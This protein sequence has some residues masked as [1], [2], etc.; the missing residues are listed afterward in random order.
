MILSTP[1]HKVKKNQI[2]KLKEQLDHIY[3]QVDAD[4]FIK[5]D[6]IQIPKSFNSKQDIE[7][8]AF[9]ASILAWGQRQTIIKNVNAILDGMDNSPYEFIIDHEETDLKRFKGFVHR[10]FNETDLLYFIEALRSLYTKYNSLEDAFHGRGVKERISNFRDQFFD[11]EFVPERTYKHIADPRKGS[12]A[13]RLNMYLRWMVRNDQ[14]D[15]GIWTSIKAN[16]LKCPLDVHVRRSAEYLGLLNR[17]QNDWKAVEELSDNL[18]LL[19]DKDPMK[20]DIS[21]FL[22]SE[23]KL[24]E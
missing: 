4:E 23:M 21:L 22:M 24:I 17:K 18:L 14:L 7:I 15:L 3:E 2:L 5:R 10:T 20:Y 19:D 8:S 16:E 9:F 6:P 1:C 12:A 13:K 11:Q